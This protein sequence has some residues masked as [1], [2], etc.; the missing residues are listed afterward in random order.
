MS[1][2]LEDHIG[3]VSTGGRIFISFRLADDI[4]VDAQE[5]VEADDI[6]TSKDTTCTKCTMEIW[7]DKTKLITKNSKVFQRETKINRSK[8]RRGE[9]V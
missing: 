5:E 3:S 9:N 1:D 7:P 2:A 4:V 6:V 8:A